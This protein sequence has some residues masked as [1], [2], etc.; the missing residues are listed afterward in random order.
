MRDKKGRFTKGNIGWWKGKKR[1]DMTGRL[2]VSW[3]EKIGK[4]CRTC[5]KPFDVYPCRIKTAIYCSRKCRA[6]RFGMAHKG[7]NNLMWR[8][9]GVGYS[10]LHKWVKQYLGAPIRC[11]FCKRSKWSPRAVQWANKSHKYKRNLKDWISLCV[12]CH[13]KYDKKHRGSLRKKFGNLQKI[14]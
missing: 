3:K 5:K 1:P 9:D 4:K 14:K 10:G 8:G 7:E 6:I 2:N 13:K 11:A 12:Q